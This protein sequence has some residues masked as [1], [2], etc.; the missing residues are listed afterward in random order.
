MA[1]SDAVRKTDHDYEFMLVAPN[2]GQKESR[3]IYLAKERNTC[4]TLQ[5]THHSKI[6][7]DPGVFKAQGQNEG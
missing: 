7:F 1:A 5:N 4:S 6:L 3:V 2:P